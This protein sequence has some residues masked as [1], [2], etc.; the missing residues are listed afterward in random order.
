[1][2]NQIDTFLYK[3]KNY[4]IYYHNHSRFMFYFDALTN[5][6]FKVQMQTELINNRLYKIHTNILQILA[7][8]IVIFA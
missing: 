5:S 7:I 1:M 4:L 8:C 3:I 6:N 2:Y